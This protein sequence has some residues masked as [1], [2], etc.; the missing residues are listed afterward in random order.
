[1]DCTDINCFVFYTKKLSVRI[2]FKSF[3]RKTF[4]EIAL[5]LL[6][7]CVLISL[8]SIFLI[9]LSMYKKKY[10]TCRTSNYFSDFKEEKTNGTF[11]RQ[12]ESFNRLRNQRVT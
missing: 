3:L 5:T 6:I 2:C 12:N 1:M 11:C 9:K 8:K 7:I 4:R 10:F